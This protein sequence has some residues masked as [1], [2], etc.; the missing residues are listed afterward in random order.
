[1]QATKISPGKE[2]AYK[3]SAYGA[4]EHVMV[5]AKGLKRSDDSPRKDG[6]KVAYIHDGTPDVANAHIGIARHIVQ[7]WEDHLAERAEAEKARLKAQRD[8]AHSKALNELHNEATLKRIADLIGEDFTI[9]NRR[10]DAQKL[11]DYMD[12]F[13]R[14]SSTAD[15]TI[16]FDDLLRALERAAGN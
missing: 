14:Y 3:T 15:L 4:I 9:S 13:E 16:R 5:V 8:H 1:M 12:G 10:S 11:S 6:I 2:Y 7:T